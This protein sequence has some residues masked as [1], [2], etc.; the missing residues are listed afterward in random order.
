[1][2][3]STPRGVRAA[4]GSW[5][6]RKWH[7]C[8]HCC[9]QC[10]VVVLLPC[11]VVTVSKWSH[12]DNHT[13]PTTPHREPRTTTQQQQ[14][15][16]RQDGRIQYKLASTSSTMSTYFWYECYGRYAMPYHHTR[17]HVLI[18]LRRGTMWVL[19]RP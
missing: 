6:A 13:T 11:C 7:V 9:Y 12:N 15:Q 1:M 5:P 3:L 17:T 16:Q 4:L 2:N 8:M 19:T 14:E 18:E 10:C